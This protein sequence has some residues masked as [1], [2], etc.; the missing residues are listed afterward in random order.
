MLN[1][2]RNINVLLFTILIL[3]LSSLSVFSQNKKTQLQN[4]KKKLEQEIALTNKMLSETRKNRQT[5][6]HQL[7]LLNVQIKKREELL[8]A[9]NIE[10]A[11]ID[12]EIN[13]YIDEIKKHEENIEQLK[14]ALSKMIYN[15]YKTR[16]SHARLMFIFSASDFNQ[17]LLRLQYLKLYG[18]HIKSNAEQIKQAQN[19][20]SE[21]VEN[22]KKVKEEKKSLILQQQ[23]EKTKLSKSTKEKNETIAKLRKKENELRKSIKEK[24][25]AA[26]NLQNAINKIIQDE[27]AAAAK[28]TG[29]KPV[30]NTMP[31]A[32]EEVA[33]SN[34]F[35]NNKGKLPW[36]VE[37]G[38]ISNTFGSHPHPV[39][40]GIVIKNDGV[41][42]ASVKGSVARSVFNGKV[43]AVTSIPSYNNV[44]MIRH[45]DYLSVYANLATVSVK[46]GDKV[47]TKQAI[48]TLYYDNEEKNA[49]LHFELR[50]GTGL[51]NPA[52][53][54]VK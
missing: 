26:K 19:K 53:W 16:N 18:Q 22:L 1:I 15:V 39:L 11:E 30:K 7:N 29:T 27:I 41:N 51:L 17:A 43:T 32:P 54:L 46:T 24:E 38:F 13:N 50:K 9:M 37:K 31:L 42:F 5:S 44:V 4:N 28:K 47:K 35:G 21:A 40:P 12:R 36:P 48:G 45:G 2:K 25:K 33:L 14:A 49:V 52:E 6:V 23:E 10:V 34:E 3:C 8:R 20:L